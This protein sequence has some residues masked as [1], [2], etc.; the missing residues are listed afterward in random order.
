M[1]DKKNADQPD[2]SKINV[3]EDYKVKYWTHHLKV[4]REAL[5]KAVNQVG[6]SA[7]AV[8]KELLH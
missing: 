1:D 7:A 6:N 2:R 8:Q 3:A 4:T 5:Q